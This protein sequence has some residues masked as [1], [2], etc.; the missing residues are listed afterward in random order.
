MICGRNSAEILGS[1][2]PSGSL[3]RITQDLNYVNNC[4]PCQ[5]NFQCGKFQ[6]SKMCCLSFC[7]NIF[8]LLTQA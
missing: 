4:L 3:N 8:S 2:L 1:P 6:I 5:F 7:S